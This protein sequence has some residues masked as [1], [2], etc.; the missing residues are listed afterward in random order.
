[1][2]SSSIKLSIIEKP[3]PDRSRLGFDVYS[4][5]LAKFISSI[6]FPLSEISI[7]IVL[8]SIVQWI[9]INPSVCSYPCIIELVTASEIV[10]FIDYATKYIDLEV[11]AFENEDDF[12][13]LKD[14]L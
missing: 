1:M 12:N 9:L 5:S 4:G 13:L 14:F 3:M 8:S 10:D 2:F 11:P 7:N 6:P